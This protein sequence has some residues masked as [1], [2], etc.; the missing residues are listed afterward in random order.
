LL[1]QIPI[2]ITTVL[3]PNMYKI[4]GAR[5]AVFSFQ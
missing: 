4:R 3:T 1:V 2:S 5:R